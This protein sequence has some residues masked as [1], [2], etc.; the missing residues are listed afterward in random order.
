VTRPLRYSRQRAL[1]IGVITSVV[2]LGSL[3]AAAN[4]PAGVRTTA[5]TSVSSTLLALGIISIVYEMFL[6]ETVLAE[7]LEIVKLQEKIHAMRVTDILFGTSPDY[8]MLSRE[9][10]FAKILLS[11]VV[12]WVEREWVHL[13]AAAKN[14]AISIVI[15]L[16][17]PSG[18]CVDEIARRQGY[19]AT[20]LRG[21]MA[22]ARDFLESS[23]KGNRGSLSS[24]SSFKLKLYDGVIGYDVAAFD[25]EIAVSLAPSYERK[26]GEPSIAFIFKAEAN[27]APGKWLIDQ[28]QKLDALP[29]SYADEVK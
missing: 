22:S 15:Y 16:P 5:I 4:M 6:R 19:D 12:G 9:G 18:V 8:E 14:R 20:E 23:W 11:N 26:P 3:I 28:L 25:P 13:L 1:L 24:G 17:N 7:T 27:A 2:S 21:Q 29:D 10:D